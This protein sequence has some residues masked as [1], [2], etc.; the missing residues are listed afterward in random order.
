MVNAADPRPKLTIRRPHWL[1]I[2]Y[3]ESRFVKA[4]EA[5]IEIARPGKWSWARRGFTLI[6]LLVTIGIVAILAALLFPGLARAREKARAAVCLSNLRQLAL[7]DQFYTHDNGDM[8]TPNMT[9]FFGDGTLMGLPSWAGGDIS[10]GRPDGT[11]DAWLLGT[12]A[13]QPRWGLLGRYLKGVGVF[14]CPGDPSHAGM[15]RTGPLRNRSYSMNGYVG[16]N[17]I[18]PSAINLGQLRL[19]DLRVI[20]P[21]NTIGRTDIHPDSIDDCT[22]S[23]L[24]DEPPFRATVENIPAMRHSRGDS[25]SFFDGHVERHRWS[26]S[27]FDF[28]VTGVKVGAIVTG[29]T[30]DFMWIWNHMVPSTKGIP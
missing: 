23:A 24:P 11:N 25:V 12:D 8:L 28:K 4:T 9:A 13:K 2:G 5:C 30:P 19:S 20:G 6:E 29:Q 27:D 14:R 18:N 10:Y 3:R 22:F 26:G 17:R 15:N 16:G 7:A 21:A 1:R